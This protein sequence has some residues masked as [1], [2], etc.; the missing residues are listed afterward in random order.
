MRGCLRGYEAHRLVTAPDRL[1]EPLI[2][3]GDRGSGRF[4]AAGWGETLD[5]VAERLGGIIDTSGSNAVLHLG[6]S[7]SCRGAVHHTGRLT[8]RFFN[9]LGGYTG[10]DG[11]YSSRAMSYTLPFLF[12]TT[13]AGQDAGTLRESRFILLWGA[14]IVDT[15][16]G[17]EIETVVRERRKE[18][19]PVVVIDPRRS[20]TVENLASEWIA[21]YPGSDSALMA[22][23]LWV[24]LE[25]GLADRDFID[26]TCRGF[27]RLEGYITGTADGV[28]KDPRWAEPI[29]GV[30]GEVITDL[31]RRYA[32]G[33]PAALIPGLSIQ[34]VLGGEEPVR[35]A[36]ALQAATG[37]IGKPGGSSGG[38]GWGGL[39]GPRCG[40]IDTLDGP[41]TVRFPVYRWPDAV[42]EGVRPG[43]TGGTDPVAAGRDL[44]IRAL[45][46]VGG[47]YLV[48]GSDIGKNLRAFSR[49]EFI[50]CHDLFMT[51]TAAHADVVLPATSFLEREDIVFP[52]SNYL[53][54]SRRCV[55]PVGSSRN[56]YDIFADLASRLGREEEF[57]RG[58][59]S[60]EWLEAILK[61]SEVADVDGFRRTG[62]Y[63]GG[64]HMRTAFAD[65]II[66]PEN[67]P[68]ETPSGK[69]EI[70]SEGF[71]ETGFS[72]IPEVRVSGASVGSRESPY[73]LM[74]VTPHARY[75]VNSQN[76][77]QEWSRKKER[78]ELWL[79]PFDAEER[80]LS[81]GTEVEA[82]S[83]EGS[84][85]CGVRI[86]EG[87][88]RGV[89][90]LLQG[91]WGSLNPNHLT[92]TVPTR[93]SSGSR[94]H[95]VRIEVSKKVR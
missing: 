33:S 15:R 66:D 58:R 36:V 22:A 44:P 50:V 90:C 91:G 20:R 21:P 59:S 27:D 83:A 55:D 54:Y 47:N 51:D 32:A 48:Q 24:I 7:G 40:K 8:A 86:T 81:E 28:Q 92:S 64:S 60:E 23:I 52:D 39:P 94:T 12:G 69:I 77:N 57:S 17:C 78:Q 62:I 14:N 61:S 70:L 45:Y 1:K 88:R 93:P 5:F 87:I 9:S 72:P 85:T 79:H 74:L 42:L 34:R 18:G 68:L 82:R 26:R 29:T 95:S 75:R 6:G 84:L 13:D 53:F 49:A 71:G 65:F 41:N 16:F 19:V 38:R 31:A 11:N 35:F 73:P 30:P 10:T 37:N 43:G 25:E 3:T 89:A 2:R 46:S 80:G 63:D 67:H 76:Y 4:K 56:D